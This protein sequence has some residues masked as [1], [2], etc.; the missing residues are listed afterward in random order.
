MPVNTTCPTCKK[1][2]LTKPCFIKNG[3]RKYC[4]QECYWKSLEGKPPWNKGKP[5]LKIR[6]K[7][8]WT[9]IKGISK[10]TR[11]KMSDSRK[12]KFIGE[13][14]FSWKGGETRHREYIYILQRFHP[15]ARPNG[16]VKR[17]RLVIERY[18]KRFLDSHNHVHH[19]NKIKNDD[20][21]ENLM[22]FSSNS[23][24]GRFH[25]NS[26]NVKQSEIVF[27]GRKIK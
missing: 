23:A 2:F 6:G 13:K 25:R 21:I 17:S 7:N 22:A 5:H 24:H 12:D 10:R 20:R 4:C 19:I 14:N 27:D 26:N 16:Y 3:K 8:H 1:N 15:Y 18:I 9:F 11:K